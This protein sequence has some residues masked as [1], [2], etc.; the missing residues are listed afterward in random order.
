MFRRT[1]NLYAELDNL[2]LDVLEMS[3]ASVTLR[4]IV[5][6]V[7]A[8]PPNIGQLVVHALTQLP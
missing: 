6:G 5:G 7:H 1:G 4:T 2:A 3:R 8:W